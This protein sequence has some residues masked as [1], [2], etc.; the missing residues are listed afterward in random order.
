[1]RHWLSP[2]GVSLV[3]VLV[4]GLLYAWAQ[5]T[6]IRWHFQNGFDLGAERLSG[7]ARA[8]STGITVGGTDV[9]SVAIARGALTT[10]FGSTGVLP[11]LPETE[12]IASAATITADACGGIKRISSASAVTT[13]TTH[14]ITAPSAALAGCVM[15]LL[16]V[17][18]SDAIT[19][20]ANANIK[21]V[22]GANVALAANSSLVVGCDGTAWRQLTAQLTAT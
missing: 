11:P 9:A 19:L 7:M 18:A 8:S 17:N 3:A 22:S 5:D 13:G 20:D 6:T 1:M 2:V 4:V 21:L 12:V 14:T 15:V 10:T 16:N